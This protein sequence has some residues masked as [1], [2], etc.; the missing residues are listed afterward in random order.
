MITKLKTPTAI[1]CICLLLLVGSVG[2]YMMNQET[3]PVVENG[4]VMESYTTNYTSSYQFTNMMGSGHATNDTV[5]MSHAGNLSVWINVTAYF[6]EPVVGEQGSVRVI[7]MDNNTEIFNNITSTDVEWAN[8]S[9]L[10]QKNLSVIIQAVGSDGTITG[11]SVADWYVIE[12]T[13]H[14]VWELET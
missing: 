6:H 3:A 7:L 9:N 5:N 10:S 8:A 12:I 2:I 1:L 4:P 14:V 11:E 13:A